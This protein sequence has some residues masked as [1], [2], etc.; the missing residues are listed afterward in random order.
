MRCGR[1]IREHVEPRFQIGLGW[2]QWLA[3][4]DE[5]RKR[6]VDLYIFVSFNLLYMV[7]FAGGAVLAV[8]YV[9][10]HYG[11]LPALIAALVYT[12]LFVWSSVFMIR[13][14]KTLTTTGGE[15]KPPNKPLQT[16]GG[17]QPEGGSRSMGSAA[18]G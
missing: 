17:G 13:N 6:T 18:R 10:G 8:Q 3:T 7:Y 1:Y 12:V 11:Q 5:T 4:P 9:L 2:E 14:W 15:W 16:T